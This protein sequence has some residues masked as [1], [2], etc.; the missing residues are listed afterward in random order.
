[1]KSKKSQS[2]CCQD[3]KCGDREMKCDD[4]EMGCKDS[5]GCGCCGGAP[6]E[7]NL[8][9]LGPEAVELGAM[10]EEVNTQL[11]SALKSRQ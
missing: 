10:F 7:I 8:K 4:K 3:E 2:S 11:V 1:M 5:G 6:Q 9:E